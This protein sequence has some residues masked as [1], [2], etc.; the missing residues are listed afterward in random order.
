MRLAIRDTTEH[1]LFIAD[2][3]NAC[4]KRVR[5]LGTMTPAIAQLQIVNG[6]AKLPLGFIRFNHKFPI[7][8]V[9][10]NGSLVNRGPTVP[11]YIN[12]AF[13]TNLDNGSPWICGGTLTLVGGYLFFSN[14][15]TATH[16]KIAYLSTAL[17][18][19]GNLLIP[20]IAED[21]ITAFVCWN[22][23]RT[24]GKE[25]DAYTKASY[26]KE[27]KQGKQALKGIFNGN[28]GYD[29]PLIWHTMNSI[30]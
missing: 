1:D 4:V 22:F 30:I 25:Y 13:Y 15:I 21:A 20:A 3:I 24:Y 2:L 6:K 16:V 17:D 5:N 18:N 9:N 23:T 27:W 28:Q 29:L 14:E 11:L 10:A 26:E 7:V 12:N 8:Y 19:D